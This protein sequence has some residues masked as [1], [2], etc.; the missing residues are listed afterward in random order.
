MAES[1]VKQNSTGKT[2]KAEKLKPSVEKPAV[3]D[4]TISAYKKSDIL[5]IDTQDFDCNEK[6]YVDQFFRSWVIPRSEVF[7]S[8]ENSRPYVT[9]QDSDDVV[10]TYPMK[11][12][13]FDSL[14]SVEIVDQTGFFANPAAFQPFTGWMAGQATRQNIRKRPFLRIGADSEGNVIYDLANIPKRE[15]VKIDAQGVHIV[16]SSMIDGV[17]F[18]SLPTMAVQVKPAAT[19]NGKS[20]VELL[21]P[22]FRLKHESQYTLL[23]VTIVAWFF[24]LMAKPI[25]LF[26][27]EPGAGKTLACSFVNKIVDPPN[28]ANFNMPKKIA[29]LAPILANHYASLL[30]N[31]SAINEEI[32][33][34]LATAVTKSSAGSRQLYTNNSLHVTNFDFCAILLAGINNFV[35]KDDLMSRLIHFPLEIS[36]EDKRI[37]EEILRKQFDQDLPYI[38]R[39]IFLIISETI[40]LKQKISKMNAQGKAVRIPAY[41]GRLNDFEFHAFLISRVLFGK[42]SVFKSEYEATLHREIAELLLKDITVFCTFSY[43]ESLALN[44]GESAKYTP[45]IFYNKVRDY[46]VRNGFI[47]QYDPHF[48]GSVAVFGKRVSGSNIPNKDFVKLGYDIRTG[49]G[50]TRTTTIVKL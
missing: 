15:F 33:D 6:N 27:G 1:K 5:R 25:I 4:G 20:L 49:S 8:T 37:P 28:H 3:M 16:H 18:I 7:I 14:L 36:S 30:D 12:P 23:A 9:I 31:V 19:S 47:L 10:L 11:S 2:P 48:A 42:M 41:V 39:E 38:M 13:G 35:C 43:L 50:K 44:K 21:R 45:T 32:S 26:T 22:Y 17:P 40:K 34:F 29:N 24:P 46:G